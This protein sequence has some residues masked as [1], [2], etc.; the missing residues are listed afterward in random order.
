MALDPFEQNSI[1]A[2]LSLIFNPEQII[3]NPLPDDF[4]FIPMEPGH[5]GQRE[6]STH[7]QENLNRSNIESLYNAI[8]FY[9]QNR[10]RGVRESFKLNLMHQ[11][12]SYLWSWMNNKLR[13][14]ENVQVTRE[15]GLYPNENQIA[16]IYHNLA[17]IQ[18]VEYLRIKSDKVRWFE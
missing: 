14:I 1:D 10:Y 6:Y 4:E 13:P 5:L 15:M 9:E 7:L 12:V 2:K 17:S 8:G 18:F 11:Q 16:E 3:L